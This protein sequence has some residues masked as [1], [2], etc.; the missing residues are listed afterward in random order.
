[1]AAS[2][3]N[4]TE[5]GTETLRI[6]L[7]FKD[8]KC[9][10]VVKR[11]LNSLSTKIGIDLQP[12][13]KS[14]KIQDDLRVKEKKPALVN[15]QNVVYEFKCS[16]CDASYIGFTCRHLY[17]RI[18][19]HRNSAVGKHLKSAHAIQDVTPDHFTVLKRCRDKLDCLI[20]EML[21]IRDKRPTL[22]TQSDSLR[23]KV[24]V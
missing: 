7:P 2:T 17:Q 16:L 3:S 13:F 24:F 20:F 21:L 1:M 9:A 4:S 23:A 22:N 5:S 11:Q 8:Q 14:H 6:V 19:E 18:D 10:D 15:Q 12:V